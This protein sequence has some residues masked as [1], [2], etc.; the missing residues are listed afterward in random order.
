MMAND[1]IS[2]PINGEAPVP[3][4]ELW[5]RRIEDWKASGLSQKAWCQREQL[6]LSSLGYWRKRLRAEE[7]GDVHETPRLIPVSLIQP[8]SP[9]TIR[10]GRQVIIDVGA[11][12]DRGLLGDL[13]AVLHEQRGQVLNCA[14]HPYNH[15]LSGHLGPSP[16][17]GLCNLF[18]PHTLSPWCRIAQEG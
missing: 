1:L 10:L 3:K 6:P 8:S 5:Q 4:R 15:T 13:I 7:S 18:A 2:V 17:T 11:S 9:L 12:V 16:N 14:C